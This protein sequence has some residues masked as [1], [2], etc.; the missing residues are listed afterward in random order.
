MGLIQIQRCVSAEPWF[1]VEVE[2]QTTKGKS[3]K[4]VIPWPDDTEENF[5]C[6]CLGYIHRGYCV[7][8]KI[9][10]AKLCRWDEI[11]GPE[12]QDDYQKQN[13]ICPRCGDETKKTL[14]YE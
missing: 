3:Y 13:L 7:H 9:V 5:I 1:V 14:E 6:E 4:V 2:S 12:A 8:Q 11:S 10:S